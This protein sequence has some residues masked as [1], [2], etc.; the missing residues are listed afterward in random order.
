VTLEG[1][2]ARLENSVETLHKENSSIAST[3]SV[4]GEALSGVRKVLDAVEGR[5]EQLAV[6]MERQ[7]TQREAIERAFT[8]IGKHDGRIS[9]V[10]HRVAGLEAQGSVVSA[11]GS[12][13]V[14]IVVRVIA[15]G[16]VASIATLVALYASRG[17]P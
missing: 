17:G 9:A 15:T 12:S 14:A 8:M 7:V 16:I 2:V 11:A 10:E 4:H 13:A 1:R 6:L 5:L 3:L